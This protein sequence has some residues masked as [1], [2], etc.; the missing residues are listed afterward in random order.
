MMSL[1]WQC[2]LYKCFIEMMKCFYSV[3]WLAKM[4]ERASMY[5]TKP[6]KIW[7]WNKILSI[8]FLKLLLFTFL[9]SINLYKEGLL[10]ADILIHIFPRSKIANKWC[11]TATST[12][13][14]LFGERKCLWLKSQLWQIYIIP[15]QFSLYHTA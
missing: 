7:R 14:V 5:L 9:D 6:I 2:I 13:P 10:A 3:L 1:V 4:P 11:R 8:F 15:F 12:V